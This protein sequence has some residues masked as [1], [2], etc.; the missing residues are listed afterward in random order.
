M[1]SQFTSVIISILLHL[2]L[3]AALVYA[4]Q[5]KPEP[6]TPVNAISVTL[7]AAPLVSMTTQP[8]SKPAVEPVKAVL[9]VPKPTPAP[10]TVTP[11]RIKTKAPPKKPAL[12][13]KK[14]VPTKNKQVS[15]VKIQQSSGKPPK[16]PMSAEEQQWEQL[17]QVADVNKAQPVK[18]ANA[19]GVAS[20]AQAS[21]ATMRKASQAAVV[22]KPVAQPMVRK[23]VAPHARDKQAKSHYQSQLRQLIASQKRYPYHAKRRGD[24]GVVIVAFVVKASGEI[25][26]VKI[27]QSSGSRILDRAARDVIHKVSGKLPFP[28]GTSKRQWSFSVPLTY[29]LR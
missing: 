2:G 13:T 15:V 25:T 16:K 22:S 18:T 9:A 10:K 21:A 5:Q 28:Q 1:I 11:T 12:V 6:T 26:D 4:Y 27:Q 7:V 14:V 20:S 19:T 3:A 23:A 29:R 24:E 8:L 17:L